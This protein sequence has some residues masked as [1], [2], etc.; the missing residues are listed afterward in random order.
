MAH[1][2]C[3]ISMEMMNGKGLGSSFTDVL[4]D[5]G[6]SWLGFL[7]QPQITILLLFHI[8]VLKLLQTWTEHQIH[9]EWTWVQKTFIVKNFMY[10]SLQTVDVH[11]CINQKAANRSNLVAA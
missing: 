5:L 3:P 4:M 7:F 6:E 2:M 9:C 11:C 1:L 10:F 8:F